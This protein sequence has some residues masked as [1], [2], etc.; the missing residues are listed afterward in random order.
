MDTAPTKGNGSDIPEQVFEKFLQA[1]GEAGVSVEVVS[2]LRKALLEDKAFTER[3]LKVAIA[4]EEP[5]P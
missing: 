2:R 4:G 1:L 3:S 5:L